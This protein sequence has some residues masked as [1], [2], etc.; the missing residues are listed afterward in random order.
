MSETGRLCTLFTLTFLNI[1]LKM[2]KHLLEEVETGGIET[3]RRDFST[4]KG[5]VQSS[6]KGNSL[7]P[8]TPFGS[9]SC[10]P[11]YGTHPWL[12]LKALSHTFSL[13]FHITGGGSSSR[14]PRIRSSNLVTETL[15]ARSHRWVFPRTPFLKTHAVVAVLR[16]VHQL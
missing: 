9:V 8:R 2:I 10:C 13:I 15:M 14:R 16:R 3:G 4:R 1:A 7:H 5:F 12:R 11:S 6:I